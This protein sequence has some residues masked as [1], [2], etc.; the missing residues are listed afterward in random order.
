M[1]LENNILDFPHQQAAASNT[2][3]IIVVTT[4]GR[5]HLIS[6]GKVRY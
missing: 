4:P 3:L 5:L 2:K 1:I 6:I